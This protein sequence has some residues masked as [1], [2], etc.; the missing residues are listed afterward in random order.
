[1]L[2][3]GT[4][5]QQQ[6]LEVGI[7][8]KGR[9]K[10]TDTVI[11]ECRLDQRALVPQEVCNLQRQ[12]QGQ[13]RNLRQSVGRRQNAAFL[14][15]NNNLSA[16]SENFSS[17]TKQSCFHY[18]CKIFLLKQAEQITENSTVQLPHVACGVTFFW[19]CICHHAG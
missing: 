4:T 13:S 8:M 14:Y 3:D 10:V 9:N 7:E 5:Q 16:A 12:Y 2:K 6:R 11:K 1:M 18:Q 19:V 15:A 17:T